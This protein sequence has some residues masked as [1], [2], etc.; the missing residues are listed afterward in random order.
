MSSRKQYTTFHNEKSDF[1]FVKYGVPQ[2]SVLGPLLFLIYINDISRASNLGHF[3]IFAD[4]SN[5]FVSADNK[6]DAYKMANEVM[7][8]VYLY[9]LSNQ[10]HINTSKCVY[11]YFRP[12]L[13]NQ[14]RLTCARSTPYNRE[15]NIHVNGKKL[16]MVDKTR[17]LGVIIDDKLN[18]D[19]H[20]EY[21]EK[22]MLSTIVLVKRI[23]KIVPESHYKS[24][25]HSLFESHLSYGIS[26]WGA[27]YSSKLDTLFR[28]QKRCI[29]ILF[30]ATPSFDHPEY[31]QTCARA[32]TWIQPWL[33]NAHAR[34]NSLY[35]Q[36]ITSPSTEIISEY[37]KIKKYIDEHRS[38]NF[39]LEHTKPLF[40]KHN[41]LSLRSLYVIRTVTELFKILKYRLPMCLFSCF[42]FSVGSNCNKLLP[43]KCVLGIS[44]NNFVFRASSL[45]NKFI[46]QLLSK[47]SLSLI[48]DCNSLG[49]K[50]M[51]IIPGSTENSDLTCSV[52][53]FKMRLKSVLFNHQKSGDSIEWSN[54]N[55]EF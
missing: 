38:H 18:W 48:N 41:I 34:K 26:C 24:I 5:I 28:I 44:M 22:K 19:H 20:I 10:L 16:K 8:S 25:Y 40:N 54:E 51:L 30:G 17:F 49:R 29:R 27:A 31:Y 33:V 50:V 46:S 21:L 55:F 32:R 45:W 9:L 37:T 2:G 4:D 23:R 53:T 42:R 43:P 35:V 6:A 15:F 52:P 39:V 11:M 13:N 14:E 47:P 12:N 7:K 1:G 36:V 3:V